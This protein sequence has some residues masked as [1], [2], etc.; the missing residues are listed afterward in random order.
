MVTSYNSEY[1]VPL[2]FT[3]IGLRPT[4]YIRGTLYEIPNPLKKTKRYINKNLIFKTGKNKMKMA[5]KTKKEIGMAALLGVLV[6]GAVLISGCIDSIARGLGEEGT[7]SD[8][9]KDTNFT[10][11]KDNVTPKVKGDPVLGAEVYIEQEPAV[12][13]ED[14]KKD[15]AVGCELHDQNLIMKNLGVDKAEIQKI[16]EAFD[17]E[18]EAYRVYHDTAKA[19]IQNMRALGIKDADIDKFRSENGLISERRFIG[20]VNHYGIN[21]EGIKSFKAPAD[22]N[23]VNHYGIN[24]EG[25]KSLE[26]ALNDEIHAAEDYESARLNT[27]AR[28]ED[29]GIDDDAKIKEILNALYSSIRAAGTTHSFAVCIYDKFTGK[30]ELSNPRNELKDWINTRYK[31]KECCRSCDEYTNDQYWAHSF[32]SLTIPGYLCEIQSGILEIR[33]RNKDKTDHLLIGGIANSNDTWEVSK[34]LT[35]LGVQVGQE[36]ILTLNLSDVAGTNLLKAIMFNG[37]LDVVVEDDSPV[38]YAILSLNYCCM[39]A[40]IF[41]EAMANGTL[42]IYDGPYSHSFSNLDDNGIYMDLSDLNVTDLSDLN[43]TEKSMATGN[44]GGFAIGGFNAA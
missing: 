38:D 30:S 26:T 13:E 17:N 10:D 23:T 33:V 11:V 7:T 31:G 42:K 4:S 32:T 25:I 16:Q 29:A 24:E 8:N 41:W 34:L 28:I 12:K 15:K 1:T 43:V 21:E 35:D 40:E 14:A 39:E 2:R 27:I 3:Q 36:E 5:T 37:F 44:K 9:G 19:I 22:F 20:C 6:V 18:I